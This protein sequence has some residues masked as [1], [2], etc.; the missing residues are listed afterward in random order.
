MAVQ[1]ARGP[2]SQRERGGRLSTPPRT[3]R[4][5][6]SDLRATHG[7]TASGRLGRMTRRSAGRILMAAGLVVALA[8]AGG[9]VFNLER[10]ALLSREHPQGFWSVALERGAIVIGQHT[11]D[12]PGAPAGAGWQWT[13]VRRSPEVP[14][15]S[16]FRPYSWRPRW[17]SKP[18]NKLIIAPLWMLGVPG[19]A[20]A[21]WGAWMLRRRKGGCPACGYLLAGLSR[22]SLVCP[23][24]GVTL[25]AASA[26]S[27]PPPCA[28]S[29][30]AHG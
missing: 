27:S 13:T 23:E 8:A 18:A 6:G 26:P 17:V 7:G 2:R 15:D 12:N 10:I 24:C 21:G 1:A 5:R 20:L 11:Y 29:T 9:M 25:P 22:E 30:S 28:S 16:T 19:V 4:P 14:Q 3:Q